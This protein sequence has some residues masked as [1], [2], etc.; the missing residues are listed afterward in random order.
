MRNL[1]RTE[2]SALQQ[3]WDLLNPRLRYVDQ[4]GLDPLLEPYDGACRR[5]A[6]SRNGQVRIGAFPCWWIPRYERAD[7]IVWRPQTVWVEQ[8]N[9]KRVRLWQNREEGIQVKPCDVSDDGRWAI[10][11][12]E[13]MDENLVNVVAREWVLLS[14]ADRRI[15]RRFTLDKELQWPIVPLHFGI[16]S[17]L[18]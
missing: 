16:G 14:V 1:N 17:V 8:R 7:P 6:Y 11:A 18:R 4:K 2:A 12:V 13:R 15:V 10:V 3:D 5:Y 9:R